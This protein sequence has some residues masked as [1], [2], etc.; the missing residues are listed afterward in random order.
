MTAL[1]QQSGKRSHGGSADA[2]QIDV[3]ALGHEETAWV[4]SV[5]LAVAASLIS[6]STLLSETFSC[7]FTPRGKVIFPVDT[8]PERRPNATGKSK[9][10]STRMITSC[11]V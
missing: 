9:P 5:R 11:S 10:E 1:L 2:N 7:A 6:S 4:R 8:W 3:F